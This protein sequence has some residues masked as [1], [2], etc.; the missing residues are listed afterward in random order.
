MVFSQQPRPEHQQ[1][2]GVTMDYRSYRITEHTPLLI[3]GEVVECV[4]NIKCL[5]IHITSDL[6][7]SLNTAHL[8]KKAQQALLPQE[9]ETGW[10]L[11]LAA[12]K[13]LQSHNREHPLS[14]CVYGSCT[15]QDR[16]DLAQVLRTAQGIMGSPL[17][18]LDSICW[19]ATEARRICCRPHPP[20]KWT[21]CTTS[22][23]KTVQI[24][25]RTHTPP[26]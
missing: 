2:K 8:V 20:G 18:E 22:F 11:H 12:C 19:T 25:K 15:A 16:M 24:H 5:G 3:D 13:L 7:W 6:A 17:P 14:Q 4:D 23:W 21:V 10:T 1:E 26:D 9:A